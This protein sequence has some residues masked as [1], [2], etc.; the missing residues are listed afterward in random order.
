MLVCQYS[1]FLLWKTTFV[2]TVNL[3]KIQPNIFEGFRLSW[4]G[5]PNVFVSFGSTQPA[6]EAAKRARSRGTIAEREGNVRSYLIKLAQM[7]Q[8]G[9]INM[10][11]SRKKYRFKSMWVSNRILINNSD[12]GLIHEISDFANVSYIREELEKFVVDEALR[13]KDNAYEYREEIPSKLDQNA[14]KGLELIKAPEAWRVL[15]GPL[16]AGEG[17]I[18]GVL[19]S[20]AYAGH[21][22]LIQNFVGMEYGFFDGLEV[23][24]ESADAFTHATHVT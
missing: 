4:Q 1:L 11:S 20:G 7:E 19:D 13:M 3:A 9:V 5:P 16:K 6:L 22:T 24:V 18:V 17:V 21:E 12:M 2:F 23:P 15:G 10:L 14:T 8:A